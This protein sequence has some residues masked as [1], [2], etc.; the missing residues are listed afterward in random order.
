[1][2]GAG[3]LS[4][5]LS[6]RVFA[7]ALPDSGLAVG[8]ILFLA[9][10]T[11]LAFWLGQIG[12]S[13][14]WG[15][16]IYGVLALVGA[17]FWWRDRVVLAET[18]RVQR[19]ALRSVEILFL[20]VFLGFFVLRGFW[21]DTSGTN[22]EKGMDG[23]L[24]A[25]LTRA[26]RLPPP[27]PYAAGQ[28]MQSYY[29][30]G[31]L[32]AALLTRASGTTTRWSYN[33]MCATLPALCC[34]ALFSLGAGL[35]GRLRGGA[36][37]AGAVL[38]GGTLQPIYQWSLR[39]PYWRD[40]FPGL[41]AFGIS[42]VIPF[43]INE[44]PWFTFNQGDLHAHY[45]DF[46]F[47]LALMALAWSLY[48]SKSRAV[49][50]VAALV[51]GAQIM[52]NTW[53]FPVYLVLIGLA[54]VSSDG[55]GAQQSARIWA[56]AA[57]RLLLGLAVAVGA[58]VV[59]APF[60][61]ALQSSAA[62]PQ[63]LPQPASPLREWLLFWGPIALGWWAF[64]AAV[65]CRSSRALQAVVGAL[66]LGV[67]VSALGAQWQVSS[68]LVLPL[69]GASAVV[70]GAG[71]WSLRGRERFICVLA[72]C[73]LLAVGWSETTW[74][75]FLGAADHA[76]FDDYKRQDTVFKFG[77]Q[78][79]ML[80]GTASAAGVWLA[81][82]RAGRT[83]RA[84]ALLLALPLASVM[85][86]GNLAFTLHRMR[87]PAMIESWHGGA[88][89]DAVRFD[90]WDGWAH[91]APPE[92]D[93]ATWLERNAR[94]GEAIVEAEKKEGGDFS[95]S[96]RYA[97]ATGIPTIVGPLAHTF[98]WSPANAPMGRG[99]EGRAAKSG[100]EW[101]E[102]F[103]RKS[104]VRTIYDPQTDLA[105]RAQLLH[106]YGVKYLVWGELERQEYGD[107]IF[108]LLASSLEI[109]AQFGAQYDPHRVVIF[110]SG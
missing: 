2:Q 26:Q 79:W 85:L 42:R 76:G 87:V 46:P 80:W 29:Y 82:A 64:A 57:R 92:Q 10:W 40:H 107:A 19:R 22:G 1:M 41:D 16:A 109:A 21:S 30:F 93:A 84:A 43:T 105:Q 52:I 73:G 102:V 71:A 94:P 8:R 89:W 36:F 51:L 99:A 106:R 17:V 96:P 95:E 58:L 103:R 33:W 24:I 90:A 108:P 48:C 47:A 56:L 91:L 23:A 67:L 28:P 59:A 5:A 104:D 12:V 83:L 65:I 100:R 18:L 39:D 78:G 53:D 50:A 88:G 45:F 27:N 62:P 55:A 66:A 44:F 81:L 37:V 77:L 38:V 4:F 110:R 9:V 72:L 68:P 49:A 6:R 97:N 69:I 86:A 34:T 61:L 31:H 54:L 13:V 25:A 60:L 3:W 98:Y 20:A 63:P 7:G 15:A 75:G 35:T 32:E 14:A 11:A 74:A 70:A 101:S